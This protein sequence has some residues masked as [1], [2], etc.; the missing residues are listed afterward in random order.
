MRAIF[1]CLFYILSSMMFKSKDQ[2]YSRLRYDDARNSCLLRFDPQ[3]PNY[4][5]LWHRKL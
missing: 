5:L 2:I 3:D 4:Q 1:S